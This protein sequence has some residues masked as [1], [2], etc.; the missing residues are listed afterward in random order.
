MP[1]TVPVDRPDRVESARL[2][3]GIHRAGGVTEPVAASVNGT[4]ITVDTG[5]ADEF[6]EFFAP[7]DAAVPASILQK[8]NQI[9]I[10]AQK[11]ATIT[12]VQIVT[13]STVE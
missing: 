2:L 9:E 3:V 8:T 4:S 10:T 1:F 6:S 13:H 11:Q 12:S 7:L 5:D